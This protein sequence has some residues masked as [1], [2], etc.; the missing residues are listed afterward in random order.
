[1]HPELEYPDIPLKQY[2]KKFQNLFSFQTCQVAVNF[3]I[4]DKRK[5]IV[6]HSGSSRACGCNHHKTSIH[7]EQRALEYL[8]KHKKNKNLQVYI[9]RW[10]KYGEIKSTYCCT[11]CSQLVHKYKYENDVFTFNNGKRV[12]AIIENPELSLAYKIKYDLSH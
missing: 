2:P 10:S 7:A 3:W 8:R 9:W 6:V 12:N 1:M 5:R 11:S 4:Y